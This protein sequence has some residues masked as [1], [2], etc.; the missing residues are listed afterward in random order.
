MIF[1]AGNEQICNKS[2]GPCNFLDLSIKFEKL[3]LPC[4]KLRIEHQ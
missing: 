2:L 3:F 1:L 4:Y